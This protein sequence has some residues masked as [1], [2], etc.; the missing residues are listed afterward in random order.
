MAYNKRDEQGGQ[1][2]E[3]VIGRKEITV[4]PGQKASIPVEL[5]NRGETEEFFELQVKGIP[6]SWVSI[7][8]PVVRLEAGGKQAIAFSIEAP[9]APQ[10]QAGIFPVTVTAIVQGDPNRRGA[11]E[12]ALK[13]AAFEVQGRI[14]V[15]LESTQFSVSPGSRTRIPIV[16]RNQGL[17]ED[18]FRLAFDGIPSSW[19]STASPV[20]RLKPG[21]QREIMVDI[22]PPRNP[23]SKAG[24]YPFQ[25][26]VTSLQA[27]DQSASI[28]C[29]LTVTAFTGFACEVQPSKVL[30][31][32]PA[33]IT[34][35]NQG[36]I[37][38]SY[39]LTWQSENDALI[40]QPGAS[41]SLRVPPGETR[42]VSFTAR[43]RS[44][45]L[46]G[47]G[48]SY[49]YSVLVQSTG[50]Q[51][52]TVGGAVTAQAWIPIW[53]VPIVLAMCLGAVFLAAWAI[54]RLQS[55][56]ANATETAL[57]ESGQ[58]AAVTQTAAFHQTQ[59]AIAGGQDSDGDGLTDRQEQGAGT[60]P[61]NPDSDGDRLSDGEEELRR[62]TNPLNPDT[63]GDSLTDGDEVLTHGTDPLNP[64]T[65]NDRLSDG[66][67]IEVGSD[68]RSPDTDND[69][70][71]DGNESPPCPDLLNPDSDGDGIVD[72]QDL[73]PC[74]P[75][76][77]ALTQTAAAVAPTA[78]PVT[79]S[80]GPTAAPT[81]TPTVT[82]TPPP[83]APPVSG[84]IAF[85]SNREGN[86][87]VYALAMPALS[88]TKLSLST[89][90]D[91]HPV[92]SPDGSLIAFSSTRD[93]NAEI[94]LMNANGTNQRNLTNHPA[95]DIYPAWSPDGQWIAFTSNRDGQQEI[96]AVRLDGTELRN[97]SNNPA[98][99]YQPTWLT[100]PGLFP[101]AGERIAFTTT[102][103]GNQEIYVMRTDGTEQ[104]NITNNPADDFYPRATR[105]G[106]RIAFASNR[107]GNQEVYVMSADGNNQENL[108]DNPAQD[109]YPSWSPDAVWIVFASNREAN[110][111]IYLMRSDGTDLFN[112]TQNLAQDLYPAWR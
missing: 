33:Q 79:P 94:Y 46:A 63:D 68:P 66:R 65:D 22:L 62:N 95:D 42:A 87:G 82:L 90:V 21:E 26:L 77:P 51:T 69:R 17:S 34:I 101:T 57:A 1:S 16:L 31:G 44:R 61:N 59:A 67:E 73:N 43:P 29:T 105:S 56:G 84:T 88:V 71:A 80:P 25:I 96:Y 32:Q 48:A 10:V 97:L 35:R 15:L 8:T 52:L 83:P 109:T 47:G 58:I 76:N 107:D 102:R 9:P 12:F 98:N 6:Q 85:E 14:G 11:A 39:T 27:P 5:V 100:D 74:D 2:I 78:T 18:D 104:I 86:P 92:Y 110:F 3:V 106:D 19:V 13:V 70:L 99:D 50:K 93:G 36:N 30:A 23:Q 75:N 91:T 28:D 4:V 37:Q 55:Q 24:R 108:T 72:G 112:L 89:G 53:V 38:D 41:Q 54:F 7:P 64:D 103:D 40:F 111:D 45:P 60:D 81:L 49:E 20:T